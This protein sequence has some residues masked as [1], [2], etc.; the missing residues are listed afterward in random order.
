MKLDQIVETAQAEAN[1]GEDLAWRLAGSTIAAIGSNDHGE[2][3][4]KVRKN[5]E[6]SEFVI[7]K[8]EQ[9]EITLYELMPGDMQE[10]PT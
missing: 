2:I 6:V 3:F 4:L 5:G 9:G 10:L 7:G 8:D 1:Y